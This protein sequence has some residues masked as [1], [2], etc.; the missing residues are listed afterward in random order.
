VES[1][2][3]LATTRRTILSIVLVIVP[4]MYLPTITQEAFSIPKLVVLITGVSLV[5]ATKVIDLG[6]GGSWPAVRKL[7]LPILAVLVPLSVSWIFSPYR[8]W[9]W[10]GEQARGEGLLP[11]L[12]LIGLAIS[13]GDSFK[14]APEKLCRLLT[15]AGTLVSIL[16]LLEGFGFDVAG[17]PL[18]AFVAGPMGNSN[19]L[20][21]FLA[22]VLPVAMG[23]WVARL[24]HPIIGLLSTALIATAILMSFSQ[25]AWLAAVAGV[26]V[27][28][29]ASLKRSRTSS[30]IAV[31]VPAMVGLIAAGTV[32]YALMDPSGRFVDTGNLTRALWWRSAVSMAAD[33]P[34]VGHGPDAYAMEAVRY[35][36]PEDALML[37][38]RVSNQ[39][40]STPLSFLTAAGIP[41]LVGYLAAVIWGISRSLKLWR[42]SRS[43]AAV[44]FVGALAAYCVGALVNGHLMMEFGFWICLAGLTLGPDEVGP[45]SSP[46]PTSRGRRLVAWA[47][48]GSI[49]VAGVGWASTVLIADIKAR[50]G[51]EA[52]IAGDTRT[53]SDDL[54]AAISLRDE[55]VYREIYADL[56]GAHALQ[57]R[58]EGGR[59]IE[60]LD[61]VLDPLRGW[62]KLSIRMIHARWLHEWSVFDPSYEQEALAIYEQTHRADPFNPLPVLYGADIYLQAGRSRDAIEGLEEAIAVVDLHPD[63][64]GSFVDLWANLAIAEL[65]LGD[66]H[67]ADVALARVRELAG[68]TGGASS[69]RTAL[70]LELRRRAET[71]TPTS[72]E[73]AVQLHFRCTLAQLRLVPDLEPFPVESVTT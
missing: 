44:L 24:W 36:V 35:R 73:D 51:L 68:E 59:F 33:S 70:A 64:S 18:T 72:E 21:A 22:I 56:L 32:V 5:L 17:R 1:H 26:G 65:Q 40:H 39:P 58:E 8:G 7:A 14:G 16:A 4:I 52:F 6:R 50:S 47:V 12:L 15:L 11:Y 63:Y 10:M 57:S 20:G 37:P 19:F 71:D 41:G 49:A 34:L 60:E 23:T 69:C 43:N 45:S 2:A 30:A 67:A 48:A 46:K 13:L 55:Y 62:P 25:G 54:R 28:I 29:A 27:T 42:G 9:A 53:G 3:T 66:L 61:R 31:A 38:D